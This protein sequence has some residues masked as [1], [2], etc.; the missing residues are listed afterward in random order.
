LPKAV[1]AQQ[2]YN[3][4]CKKKLGVVSVATPE[5]TAIYLAQLGKM[6]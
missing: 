6:V 5:E 3:L 4:L 2:A 1:T